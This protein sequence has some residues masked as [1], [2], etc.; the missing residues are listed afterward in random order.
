VADVKEVEGSGHVDDLLARLRFDGVREL[1][2]RGRLS[3]Q[4][5]V[6]ELA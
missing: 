2:S 5:S 3:K 6:P 4:N 1:E